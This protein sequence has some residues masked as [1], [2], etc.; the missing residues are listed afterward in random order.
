MIRSQI[1]LSLRMRSQFTNQLVALDLDRCLRLYP[2]LRFSFSVF[3]LSLLLPL[4]LSSQQMIRSQIALSLRMRSQFANQLVALDLDR[5]AL[6]SI[7]LQPFVCLQKLKLRHN[8]LA[9]L[10]SSGLSGL[11]AL[12]VLD[13]RNNLLSSE[14]TTEHRRVEREGELRVTTS[15]E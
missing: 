1:A 4:S 7:E 15:N 3:L 6:T 10:A 14:F 13:L 5:C 12:T 9:Y 2:P 8:K 11:S